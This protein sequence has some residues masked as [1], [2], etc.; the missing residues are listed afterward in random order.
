MK[1][2]VLGTALMMS[3]FMLSA[4]DKR[5]EMGGDGRRAEQAKLMEELRL[6]EDQKMKMKDLDDELRAKM[7]AIMQD[8][9][10]SDE[11][12]KEK[13]KELVEERKKALSSVLTPE[14][15]ELFNSRRNSRMPIA[16][17]DIMEI[18]VKLNL[19]DEQVA[20]FQLLE[21][22]ENAA[23]DGQPSEELIKKRYG[24]LKSIATTEQM[25]MLNERKGK[26]KQ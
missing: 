19:S 16:A 20:K 26:D 23:I 7:A 9:G 17:M 12:K 8:E 22:S 14:Q 25:S 1:K 4:Q 15:M 6:T 10:L 24:I 18:R 21:R 3:A 13:R 11:Q 5:S 2:W